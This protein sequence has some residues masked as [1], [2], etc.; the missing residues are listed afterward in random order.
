MRSR[1]LV[2]ALRLLVSLAGVAGTTFVACSI[3]V[4]AATAGFVY[5]ILV[6]VIASTWGFVESAVAAIAATLAYNFFFLPPVRT[7]TIA[8]PQ[9][10]VA[11]FSFLATSL[12]A[13]RLSTLAKE[14]ARDAIER[15]QDLER[16]YT[17]SRAILL[18]Q[19]GEQFAKELTNK[20]AETFHLRAAVLFDRRACEFFRAGPSDFEGMDE[21]LRESAL[22]GTSF[23]DPEKSRVIVA[24]RLGSEPIASLALQGP[25]M[26]DAV[27]QGI[28]NLVAI[29]L[30]RAKAQD[31]AHQVEAA[32]QSEQLRTTLID[33]MAHEFKTPL[34]SIKAA[35][36]S[37]L[38]VPD[39]PVEARTEMIRV[40]DEEAEHLRTLIDDAVEMARL[41]TSNIEVHLEPSSLSEIVGSAV[42]GMKNEIDART[43]ILDCE[44]QDTPIRVD[45]RLIKLAIR[46]LVDNAL[47]Y[48]DPGTPVT[49]SVRHEDAAS[50]VG[51]TDI[52]HEIPP[53]EQIRVFDR[54]WRS[55]SVKK[56]I[57]GSGLG[58]SIAH[59]I[60]RAHGGELTLSSAARKTTFELRLPDEKREIR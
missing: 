21:Q 19:T 6:L 59:G 4:N 33:A 11:L 43:V 7:F 22:S 26:P 32:R 24:V 14:R 36:S 39:Q 60:A 48:A 50:V 27:L 15:Q 29:G 3:V 53:A 16:L 5:L 55:P 52:G 42:A 41:D 9:N 10:W 57:P 20:L 34:T 17:F 28:A 23:S 45:R 13:S 8:D 30:E 44:G 51:V 54:F 37:L 31:L 1:L 58:L 40:A 2:L 56:Q 47:K 46:Q 35:T 25:Q 38:A 49:V 12:I 18:I